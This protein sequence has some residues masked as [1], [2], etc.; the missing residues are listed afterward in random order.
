[1]TIRHT[2]SLALLATCLVAR[3]LAST[4]IPGA[5]QAK[6]IAIV[7][8]TVHTVS[9]GTIN[10]GTVL[11]DGGKIVAVGQN[12]T[13]PS[14]AEIIDGTGKHVYPGMIAPN[15][16]LGLTEIDAVRATND[17]TEVGSVNPNV[18][19]DMAYNPDSD[20][21]PTV[22]SN[23]VTTAEIT[24]QGGT[25]AGTSSLLN[26]DGWTREDMD[27]RARCAVH[28]T[29]PR[30][31]VI[32]AW[33]MS[34]TEEEQK[35][36]MEK[37][38]ATFYGA[39]ADARAYYLARKRDSTIA[40]DQRWEAMV[41]VFDREIPLCIHASDAAQIR[42]A[43]DLGVKEN[44]RI[45]IV[46]GYD[47]WRLAPML[48]ERGIPVILQRVNALPHREEESYDMAYSMP[49]RLRDLGVKFCLSDDGSWPQRNLPFQ[50]ATA[51][52][53]GLSADEA[54]RAVTLST[55]EILGVAD[56]LGSLDAGKDAN[57]IVST[58]DLL[59]IESNNITAEYIHGRTVDLSNKQTALYQKYLKK[60]ERYPRKN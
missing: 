40:R 13:V 36:A 38:L 43:I 21:P 14:G 2:V 59:D 33:W 58:G 50:A 54:L 4:Q 8:A 26:L 48:K 34:Q 19:G 56:R 20:V 47:A 1:M 18:R 5:P 11:F 55:A 23:G 30:M 32:H 25:L 35:A 41:P 16:T 37:D 15:T 52:G 46:G 22:R 39:I 3:G 28:M 17:I 10:D 12:V 29:A 49:A 31:R 53:F 7:H 57:V 45:V 42:L 6:P 24:P 9:H 51:E 27:V 44:V 60:Y